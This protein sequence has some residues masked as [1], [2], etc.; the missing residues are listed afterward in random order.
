MSEN[1]KMDANW[2][3][4]AEDSHRTQKSGPFRQ[5]RFKITRR[6][7]QQSTQPEQSPELFYVAKFLVMK[8]GLKTGGFHDGIEQKSCTKVRQNVVGANRVEIFLRCGTSAV[9]CV[10]N[11]ICVVW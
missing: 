2:R 5:Q 11:V 3:R 6:S 8:T 4:S 7:D 1:W 10:K 9:L